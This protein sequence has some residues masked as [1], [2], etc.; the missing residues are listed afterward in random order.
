[1]FATKHI[2]HTSK[3]TLKNKNKQ[4]PP[5][6]KKLSKHPE[7]SSRQAGNILLFALDWRVFRSC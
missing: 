7:P 4:K 6:Q 3:H 5:K 1:M 2:K